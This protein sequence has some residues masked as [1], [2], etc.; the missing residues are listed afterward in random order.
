MTSPTPREENP[1]KGQKWKEDPFPHDAWKESFSKVLLKMMKVEG[2][3]FNEDSAF[4]FIDSLSNNLLSKI[5]EAIEGKRKD[6]TTV[7]TFGRTLCK[8]CYGLRDNVTDCECVEFN[9]GIEHALEV[10]RKYKI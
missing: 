5:E 1:N 3:L 6:T 9:K 4:A 2:E 7:D 8:N 10:I